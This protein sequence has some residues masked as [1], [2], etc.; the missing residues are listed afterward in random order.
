MQNQQ[1]RKEQ[2]E[3][4]LALNKMQQDQKKFQQSLRKNENKILQKERKKSIE[5]MK[6]QPNQLQLQKQKQQI[7]NRIQQSKPTEKSISNL[8]LKRRNTRSQLLRTKSINKL[9]EKAKKLNRQYTI[10]SILQSNAEN[11]SNQQV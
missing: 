4:K 10:P 5:N 6:F 2:Q 8:S 3:Q 7:Q 9:N 11:T 1:K